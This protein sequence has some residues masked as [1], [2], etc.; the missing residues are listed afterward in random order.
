MVK[1]DT[2]VRIKRIILQPDERSENLPEIT[3][4][5]PLEMWVKGY[6]VD[7]ANLGDWV[8]IKTITGR[9]EEGYLVEVEPTFK[10]NYGDFVKEI[11][12]IDQILQ[13][14]RRGE[15]NE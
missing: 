12:E 10:H 3:K 9:D 15:A 1:K 13:Q 14:A 4:S 2:W 11:L 5:F 8:K 6:L 7:D